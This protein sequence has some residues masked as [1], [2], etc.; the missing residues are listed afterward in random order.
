MQAYLWLVPLYIQGLLI[1]WDDV[2]F[3]TQRGLPSW[4]R[5]GHPLDTMTYLAC[6]IYP[7]Y[8]SPEAF[9]MKTFI[10]LSVFSSIFITKDEFIHFKVCKGVEMWIHAVAFA[11]HPI[12]LAVVGYVWYDNPS[13]YALIAPWIILPVIAFLIYQTIFWNFIWK[14]N[15]K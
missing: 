13:T 6:L 3:H 2:Y 14:Q 11:L 7:L 5:W 15:P 4:E 9:E 1:F 12:C 8:N 10:G